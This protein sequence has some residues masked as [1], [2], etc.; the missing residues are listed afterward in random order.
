MLEVVAKWGK[1]CS[2]SITPYFTDGWA[3]LYLHTIELHLETTA[4]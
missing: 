2:G 4:L 1:L 3:L